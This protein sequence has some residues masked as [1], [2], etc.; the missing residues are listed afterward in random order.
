RQAE[1]FVLRQHAG[2]LGLVG[3][4][5]LHRVFQRLGDVLFFRQ[6]QQVV[7]AGVGR[8]VEATFLDGDVDFG[9][10]SALA[11][12]LLIFGAN[13]VFVLLVFVV[14]EL[15]KD[16]PEHR[17]GVFAGLE[18]GVGAQRIGGAPEVFFQLFELVF[19]QSRI[20]YG[21]WGKTRRLADFDSLQLQHIGN[22]LTIPQVCV[23]TALPHLP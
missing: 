9:L 15:Q 13:R 20:R 16:Q 10:F 18:V 7:I 1:V 8:Q 19:V 6:R 14:G 2:Q 11:L 23:V 17:R 12:V 3:F 21:V 22:A 5:L 4:D